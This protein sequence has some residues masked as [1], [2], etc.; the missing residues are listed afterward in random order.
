MSST[1]SLLL[2][3][4]GLLISYMAKGMAVCL[5]LRGFFC[6]STYPAGI[7][8]VFDCSRTKRGKLCSVPLGMQDQLWS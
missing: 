4:S 2:T 6:R 7:L 1:S 8:A 5:V 3:V